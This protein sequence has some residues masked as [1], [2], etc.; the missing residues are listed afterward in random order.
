MK[1]LLLIAVLAVVVWFFARQRSGSTENMEKSSPPKAVENMVV[2]AHCHLRVPESDAI[3]A[4]GR[5][6]CCEEHRQRDAG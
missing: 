4:A 2:C 1:L 5:H 3:L 6:Y